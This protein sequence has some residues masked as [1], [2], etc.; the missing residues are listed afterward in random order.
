MQLALLIGARPRTKGME[1]R[2]AGSKWW[3]FWP[4]GKAINDNAAD[5]VRVLVVG[6]PAN[7]NCVIAANSCSRCAEEPFHCD[8]MRL[9]HNRAISQLAEKV[10]LLC[11]TSRRWWCKVTIAPISILILLMLL[12]LA[13]LL[14]TVDD[15][16]RKDYFVP[17]VISEVL[18]LLFWE[19]SAVWLLALLSTI[20]VIG[21]SAL[22]M[23]TGFLRL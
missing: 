23:V 13:K 22:L 1:R 21:R 10:V 9:D 7:M 5:D 12:W 19:P 3:Y 16:W 11:V 8:T 20:C 4:Q 6:N 15:A 2:F 14:L 18:P 17:T